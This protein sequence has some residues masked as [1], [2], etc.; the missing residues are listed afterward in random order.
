MHA[1]ARYK[2]IW[3]EYDAEK[4]YKQ[5]QLNGYMVNGEGANLWMIGI[6]IEKINFVK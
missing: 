4:A 3:Y 1:N 5:R 6:E 2:T